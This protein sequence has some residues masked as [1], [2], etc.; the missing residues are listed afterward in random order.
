MSADRQGLTDVGRFYSAIARPYDLFA[1]SAIFASLRREAVGA[2]DLSAGNR[3]L[4]I[5]CGTGGNLPFVDRAVGREGTYVGVDLSSGMLGHAATRTSDC[6]VE[7]LQADASD[8]PL[9]GRF[10]GIVVTFVNGVLQDPESAVASWV[11]RLRPGGRIVFLDAAGRRGRT[12]PLEWG[13]RTFVVLAAPPSARRRS[14]ESS[15]EALIDRVERA[16]EVLAAAASV[17]RTW[18]RWRGFVRFAVAT[19][20]S[21]GAVSR[22][23]R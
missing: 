6:A 20:D 16:H 14:D 7:L 1:T 22:Q 18:T 13:F 21:N 11:D 15:N 8:L 4:D 10:D 12:G 3:V 17:E 9:R 2:L 19:T 5:G 23:E